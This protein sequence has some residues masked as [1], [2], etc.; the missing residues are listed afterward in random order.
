LSRIQN[1]TAARDFLAAYWRADLMA[2]L[3]HCTHAATIELAKS[4]PLITPACIADVLPR[5]FREIYP[6]FQGAKFDTTIDAT[7]ADEHSVLV[8][9]TARGL[10]RSGSAFDCRYAAVFEFTAGKIGRLRM[11]T[12]TRYVA[13]AF[14]S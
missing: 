3:T 8:E 2:A 1:L 7:L 12:D 6:K 9:Y 4:L 5:I 14:T 11:Y 13:E 10:L